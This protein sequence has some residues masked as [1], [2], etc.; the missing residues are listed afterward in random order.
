MS[1]DKHDRE[2]KLLLQDLLHRGYSEF[3][4]DEYEKAHRLFKEAITLVPH[5][6][7]AHAWLAAVYGRQIDTA[8]SLTDKMDLFNKLDN[9]ITTALEIDP[10]LPLARRMNGS[11]L[12]N[13]P[14]MLGGD[15]A[16]AA[17]E[18]RYCIEQGMSD[19]EI[20]VSLAKCYM[21]TGDLAKAKEALN[22]ALAIEPKNKEALQLLQVAMKE[23]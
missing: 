16:E 2:G 22:E 11:K 13:T 9:E 7:E 23:R 14:D 3:K 5:S 8:W 20:W 18:F 17:K 19:I 15:P 6:A 1:N 10:T 4:I 21:E 12:L